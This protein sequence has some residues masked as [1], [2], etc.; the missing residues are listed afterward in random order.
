[1]EFGPV[2][3]EEAEGAI[4]AHG[5]KLPGLAL[6]KGRVLS[7]AD[8]DA[9]R[10]AGP[11]EVVVARLDPDD[12]PENEAASVLARAL[13]GPGVDVA[14]PFTGRCNL[15]ASEA[16]LARIDAA[17]IDAINAVDEAVTVATLP[18]AAAAPARG[19]LATIKIIPFAAPRA[20][21]KRCLA[22]AADR[23]AVR[24]AA[25]RPA[26]AALV[27]TTLPGL[28]PSILANTEAATRARLATLGGTLVSAETCDHAVGALAA[29]LRALAHGAADPI[30][31]LG[32]SAVVDRRDVIPM[33]ILAAGG[34]VERF[35][36]PVDPGNLL[37]LGALAGKRVIGLPGCARS[38]KL[39]GF[40]WVLQR[41]AAGV[42]LDGPAIAA[43]GVGGLLA[44]IPRPLPRSGE[45]AGL[46]TAPRVCA[47]VLAAGKSSRMAPANK[48]FLEIDGRS[49]LARAVD[50]ATGSACVASV[51]VVGNDAARARA[52]LSARGVR[53]VENRDYAAGLATSLRAGIAAVP[54]DC[55]AAVILLADMPQVGAA[56]VDRLI[57]A[58]APHEGRS[59]CVATRRGKRGNPVL[60]DRAH[61]AEM[62]TLDGDQGARALIRRHEDR[63][64]EVEMDDDG[65]LV[66]LDT[67]EALAAYRA[68]QE[69]RS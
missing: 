6:R 11:G 58:Y 41:L 69:K 64:C 18:D 42:A 2:R 62:A 12:M 27:Q 7:A 48:L 22:L 13:A 19:M 59:V 50:A 43:M 63:V 68:A 21:V 52:E 23:K 26:R 51:V 46:P 39:N 1:V 65:V 25:Y 24:L 61:F 47:V 44:E 37:L 53:I 45:A 54:E 8:I 28:K 30:L 17:L 34:T 32:A 14:A 66:D 9:I 67:P 33:A 20:A 3:V 15:F 35:G 31:V 57:A 38:P 10:A 40:D 60:W 49:L 29:K 4:L 55:D 56:H 16:G 36:M 5:L